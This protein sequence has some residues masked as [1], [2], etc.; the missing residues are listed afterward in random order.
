LVINTFSRQVRRGT[1]QIE[2]TGREYD[3]VEFLA[4][5]ARRVLSRDVLLDRVWH[6]TPDADPNV[7]D[8]YVGYL[9]KKLDVPGAPKLIQPVRGVGFARREEGRCRSDGG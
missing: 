1:R 2:L 4:R 9:R 8:V 5:N 7:V 3:L 6:Q